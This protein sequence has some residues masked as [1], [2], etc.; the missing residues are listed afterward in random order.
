M[1]ADQAWKPALLQAAGSIMKT[2]R[3]GALS[4]VLGGRLSRLRLRDAARRR[5]LPVG[6]GAQ[7]EDKRGA[8]HDASKPTQLHD[9][10]LR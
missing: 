7:R 9:G 10:P 8:E 4:G 2:T 5:L 6:S 3:R 1:T